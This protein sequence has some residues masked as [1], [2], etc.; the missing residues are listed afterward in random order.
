M[1]RYTRKGYNYEKEEEMYK[2][3]LKI[4]SFKIEEE[5]L[6]HVDSYANKIGISRSE[7]IRR[8]LR[9]YLKDRDYDKPYITRRI[10]VY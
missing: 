4:V 9:Q 1:R 3:E 7:L 5:L 10:R 6:A 8:A 2:Q